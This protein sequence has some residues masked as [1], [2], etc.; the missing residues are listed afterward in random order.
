M[1][2]L[3]LFVVYPIFL[4]AKTSFTNYGDGTRSPKADTISQIVGASVVRSDDSPQYS[5]TI[6]TDGDLAT[7]PF[8]YFLVPQDDESKVFKGTRPTGSRKSRRPTSP[9]TTVG[10]LRPTATPS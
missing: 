3:T 1:L 4:T 10:S 6:A 8:T 5:L 9:S 7:G 2:M